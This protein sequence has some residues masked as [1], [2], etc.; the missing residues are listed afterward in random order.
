M[1][2]WLVVS[3]VVCLPA[4]SACLQLQK[5]ILLAVLPRISVCVCVAHVL[6]SSS[7]S[8]C[9]PHVYNSNTPASPHGE[10]GWAAWQQ[11]RR[12]FFVLTAA[13]KPVY[14]R[15]GDEQALAGACV[16]VIER[17]VVVWA[18]C[19]GKG[20]LLLAGAGGWSIEQQT[21]WYALFFIMPAP[22]L[23]PSNPCF[24]NLHPFF[25]PQT[26]PLKHPHQLFS[27]LHGRDSGPAECHDRPG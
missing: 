25:A 10:A 18:L 21:S 14:S 7:M 12:H 6:A 26:F 9:G 8:V 2:C 16:W 13:G 3:Q 5:N 1:F 24:H 27:R 4:H 17:V 11:R 22:S 20:R 23:P 19:C 15:H